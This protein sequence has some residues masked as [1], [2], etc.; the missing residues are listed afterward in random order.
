[1]GEKA[2][3][4]RRRRVRGGRRAGERERASLKGRKTRTID[5]HQ[6]GC[7]SGR[8]WF[9]QSLT[10]F[11][12]DKNK[13]K[14][15]L[16]LSERAS[17]RASERKSERG[18]KDLELENMARLRGRRRLRREADR[19]EESRSGAGDSRVK[20][21]WDGEI[22]MTTQR[23]ISVC[24]PAC[25]RRRNHPFSSHFAGLSSRTTRPVCGGIFTHLVTW[26][27]L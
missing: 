18:E 16:V 20:R 25:R 4:R 10:L 5:K 13:G 22:G 8:F 15:R 24:M 3:R 21:R 1:M 19:V 12:T 6:V 23:G 11:S 26:I 9:L 17:E 2:G 27:F 7:R 14:F